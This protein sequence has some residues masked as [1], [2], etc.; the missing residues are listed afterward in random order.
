MEAR[1]GFYATTIARKGNDLQD[2]VVFIVGTVI[3]IARR[4]DSEI[5]RIAYNGHKRKHAMK[6][7]AVTAP[8]GLILLAFGPLEGRR[9]DWTLYLRSEMDRQLEECLLVGGVQYCVY[10]YS[11]YNARPFAEVP[12]SGY[13]VNKDQSS[14]NRAMSSCRI[15]VEWIFKEVKMYWTFVDY[16]RKMRLLECPVGALYISALL[17]TNFR[18]CVYPNPIS[19]YFNCRPPLEEYLAHKQ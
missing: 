14:Y 12:L 8:D 4:R 2:C 9:H 3:G 17:L 16:K 1:V 15:T 6:F 10:G 19:Q 5:Q 11:G 18:N 7:Q 13:Q